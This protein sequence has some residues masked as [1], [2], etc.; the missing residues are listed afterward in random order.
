M[1]QAATPSI[2]VESDLVHETVH[3]VMIA[4]Q[5]L[6]N[7]VI[8]AVAAHLGIDPQAAGVKVKCDLSSCSSA[9]G[10]V[11]SAAVTIAQDHRLPA[12]ADHAAPV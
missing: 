2:K 3:S 7:V 10:I 6:E 8:A 5:D 4:D 11:H 9:G 12:E 1:R